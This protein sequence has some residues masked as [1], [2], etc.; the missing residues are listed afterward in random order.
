MS[1]L[2]KKRRQDLGIFYTPELV[3]DLII[4]I[5]LV[6]KNKEINRWKTKEGKTKYPSII[7]PAVGEGIFLKKAC[8]FEFTK[9]DWVF[10]VDL[11]AN[12]VKKWKEINLLEEFGGNNNN[13]E[14][15]FF[16]QNGLEKIQWEQHIK[17]YKYKLKKIDIKNQQFDVVLGNPPYGGVGLTKNDLTD[18]MID[19]LVNFEILPNEVKNNI[20]LASDSWGGLFHEVKLTTLGDRQIKKLN[21]FPIEILFLERFIQLAKP[22]GRISIIIP[23]GILTNS[24]SHYVREFLSKRAKIEAII[25]LPR[26][27]FKNAGTNAKTSILLMTKLKEN[28]QQVDDYHVF[29]SSIEKMDEEGFNQIANMYEKFYNLKKLI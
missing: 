5:L 6:C 26:E 18:S 1:D 22:G 4:K 7:D 29:L 25:S 9:P 16:H 15:H 13:L 24:N 19:A 28:E 10:G 27:A 11:D 14:A 3:V 8:M 21:S 2:N 17:K 12:I 20:G 23:D